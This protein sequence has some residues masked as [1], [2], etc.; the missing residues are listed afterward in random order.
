MTHRAFR[1][2]ALS[3]CSVMGLSACVSTSSLINSGFQPVAFALKGADKA[4]CYAYT[5]DARYHVN[6]PGTVNVRKS[7]EDLRVT[8]IS[9]NQTVDM[10]VP[11]SV[12]EKPVWRGSAG[13]SDGYNTQMNYSYPPEVTVD[14]GVFAA[15]VAFKAVE[16]D[17][18]DS[19]DENA[20]SAVMLPGP[21]TSAPQAASASHPIPVTAPP[22]AAPEPEKKDGFSGLLGKLGAT[23]PEA[24]D[25]E[26]ADIVEIKP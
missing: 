20:V 1:L 5:K 11:A 4:S 16:E 3:F 7:A 2:A 14:F 13:A 22:A 19:G 17:A 21:D 26:D 24:G 10:S 23:E 12:E 9:E 18:I 25:P 15:P 8:C 6:A